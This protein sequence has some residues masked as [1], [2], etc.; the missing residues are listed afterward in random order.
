VKNHALSQ[1][2]QLDISMVGPLEHLRFDIS[3]TATPDHQRELTVAT[4]IMAG[5]EVIITEMRGPSTET[6]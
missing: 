2:P 1:G 3:E 5:V 6:I 4:E